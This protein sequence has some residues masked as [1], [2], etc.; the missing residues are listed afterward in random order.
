L[1]AKAYKYEATIK[2]AIIYGINK[3]ATVPKSY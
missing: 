1:N 3:G 2:T